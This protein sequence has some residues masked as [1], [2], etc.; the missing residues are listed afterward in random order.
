LE[1]NRLRAPNVDAVDAARA[2]SDMGKYLYREDRL[3]IYDLAVLITK[4]DMCKRRDE[5]G[6]CNR[7]IQT[8][9]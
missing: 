4:L 5:G 7:G 6:S 2:L 3:P 9:F 8:L 1:R